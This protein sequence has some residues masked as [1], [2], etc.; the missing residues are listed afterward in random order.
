MVGV[1]FVY[2]CTKIIIQFVMLLNRC[3]FLHSYKTM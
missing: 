2:L 1:G 3:Y